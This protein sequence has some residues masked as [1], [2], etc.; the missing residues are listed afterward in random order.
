MAVAAFLMLLWRETYPARPSGE[1]GEAEG[2]GDVE[3]R[4]WDTW[5]RPEAGFVDLGCVGG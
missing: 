1:D 3:R 5:G 2:D 4:E